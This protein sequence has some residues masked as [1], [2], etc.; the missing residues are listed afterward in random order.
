M[1]KSKLAAVSP[2]LWVVLL[3]VIIIIVLMVIKGGTL[4]Q[5]QQSIDIKN[6]A[7]VDL[8]QISSTTDSYNQSLQDS[9]V[10]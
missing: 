4:D 5:A 10:E 9:F 3:S 7:Q 2:L 1:I 8:Q 6:Q